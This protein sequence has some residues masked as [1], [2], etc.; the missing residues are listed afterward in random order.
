V[1][2]TG[3]V[4]VDFGSRFT[5]ELGSTQGLRAKLAALAT[6]LADAPVSGPATIDVTVP[7]E[8]TVGPAPPPRAA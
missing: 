6:V 3:S 8:P 1:D 7:A 4:T 5:A 2:V